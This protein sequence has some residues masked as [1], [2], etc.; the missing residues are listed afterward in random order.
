VSHER[1]ASS[2]LPS[3]VV[4]RT[5]AHVQG[6]PLA[7]AVILQ[8]AGLVVMASG[9]SPLDARPQAIQLACR[10][11]LPLAPV[12]LGDGLAMAPVLASLV[13]PLL[14]VT[15]PRLAALL[16]WMGIILLLR[17]VIP[18]RHTGIFLLSRAVIT[19][20]LLASTTLLTTRTAAAAMGIGIPMVLS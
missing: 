14:P 12:V 1:R 11:E 13:P 5:S 17:G 10:L 8:V 19:P 4:P 20:R 16:V 3:H 7:N 2:L 6:C 9:A 18:P 15:A